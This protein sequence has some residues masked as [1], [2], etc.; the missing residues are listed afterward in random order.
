MS[1]YPNDWLACGPWVVA[2]TRHDSSGPTGFIGHEEKV[3]FSAYHPAYGRELFR[4]DGS[5]VEL[6]RAL[7]TLEAGDTKKA[8]TMLRAFI[9]E[10]QAFWNAG[11][12]DPALA[13]DMIG[14]AEAVIASISG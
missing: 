9:H 3:Y 12:L 14:T 11:I 5:T 2:G 1:E 10:V 13:D 8:I 7:A 4:S 6:V